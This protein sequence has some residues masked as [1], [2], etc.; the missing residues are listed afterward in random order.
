MKTKKNSKKKKTK[1]SEKRQKA[2]PLAEETKLEKEVKNAEEEEFFE[3]PV[4][5][6]SIS[7]EIKAP[8]LERVIE[9]QIPI[10]NQFEIQ[11]PE[12]TRE[13]RIDYSPVSNEP[14][15]SF[16]RTTTEEEEKK[17]ETNFVPPV[18]TRREIQEREIR[19]EFLKPPA[20]DWGNRIDESLLNEIGFLEDERKLPFEEQK[21]YKRLKL[22]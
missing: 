16:T 2:K 11:L 14:N 5:Q 20:E 19:Q 7:E 21:K 8:V 3:E 12:E 22:R 4:R 9:R 18:L 10:Q 6:I 17:Y 13:R 1:K 15:Y